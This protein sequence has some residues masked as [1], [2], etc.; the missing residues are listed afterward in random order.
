MSGIIPALLMIV[1]VTPRG[2]DSDPLLL[3]WHNIC[4]CTIHV[5]KHK[6]RGWVVTWPYTEKPMWLKLISIPLL[7]WSVL[8]S[9]T[10]D[11]SLGSEWESETE[12][13]ETISENVSHTMYMYMHVYI[14]MYVCRTKFAL[15][16]HM[17]SWHQWKHMNTACSMDSLNGMHLY[18]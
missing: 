7:H 18:T 3:T 15:A 9:T 16:L 4:T 6:Q 1:T 8:P 11:T 17:T 2:P 13:R 10:R 5:N 12:N 14:C